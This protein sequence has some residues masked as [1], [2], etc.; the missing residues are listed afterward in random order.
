MEIRDGVHS[1][2]AERVERPGHFQKPEWPPLKSFVAKIQK[3]N[4]TRSNGQT[5]NY[6]LSIWR[7]ARLGKKCLSR[8]HV[9]RMQTK[10]FY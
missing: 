8:C 1:Q 2:E 5:V 4:N 7:V 9:I 10:G 6:K 3:G